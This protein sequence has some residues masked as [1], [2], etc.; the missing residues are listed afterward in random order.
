MMKTDLI[1]PQI[2]ATIYTPQAWRHFLTELRQTLEERFYTTHND[3]RGDPSHK[4]PLAGVTQENFNPVLL[5][6][7]QEVNAIPVLRL[8]TAVELTPDLIKEFATWLRQEIKGLAF[9]EVSTEP[10]L[11][12]GCTFTWGNKSYDYSLRSNIEHSGTL[13]T[14]ALRIPQ[15][16]EGEEPS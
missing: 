5:S 13:I 3:E 11:L 1:L 4:L 7:E 16:A 12:G 6:L 15:G 2:L 9:I 8:K 14:K 10:N